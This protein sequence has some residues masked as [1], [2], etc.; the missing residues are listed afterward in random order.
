MA[1]DIPWPLI[2]GMRNRLIHAYFDID[3]DVVWATTTASLRNY[4][5]R[6]ARFCNDYRQTRARLDLLTVVLAMSDPN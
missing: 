5:R 3:I 6:S 4:L 2:A 1:A